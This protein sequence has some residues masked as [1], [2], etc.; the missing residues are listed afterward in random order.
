MARFA[1]CAL[2]LFGR[3][4]VRFLCLVHRK[5]SELLRW[6]VVHRRSWSGCRG[7]SSV[8]WSRSVGLVQGCSS[9]FEPVALLR[10]LVRPALLSSWSSLF[11]AWFPAWCDSLASSWRWFFGEATHRREGSAPHLTSTC[12]EARG[13]SLELGKDRGSW[14][15]DPARSRWSPGPGSLKT[16]RGGEVRDRFWVSAHLSL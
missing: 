8:W 6:L 5:G 4:V 14:R 10:G 15:L 1:F 2:A 3:E 9:W 16:T 13:D 7:S 12:S 11:S